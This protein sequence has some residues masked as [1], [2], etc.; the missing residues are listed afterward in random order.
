MLKIGL[1]AGAEFA[2]MAVYLAIVYI[3]TRRF[4]AAAQAGFGIGL[5][6]VQSAFL[7]VV[8]LGIA[9]GPVAGQNF[10]ARRGDR[11]SETF[12]SGVLMASALMIGT[13]ALCFFAAPVLIGAF[14]EDPAV[15]RIGA[16]YLYIVAWTF[17]AS[18]IIFVSSSVFQGLGN[19][20][21]PLIVG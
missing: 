2:L 16:E 8:A 5:R 6:I 18:G 10:G 12:R 7:P 9:V 13:T 14:T 3:V 11:I 19:T 4:G 21:P 1:R 15:I 20:L 17:V